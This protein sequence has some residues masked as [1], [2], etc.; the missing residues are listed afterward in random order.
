M[1]AQTIGRVGV[2]GVSLVAIVSGY[3]TVNL[4]FS[5]LSLFVRPVSKRE[6]EALEAQAN[7]VRFAAAFRAVDA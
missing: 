7:Q 2:I 6:I 4:P 1:N 3:G 5:Y